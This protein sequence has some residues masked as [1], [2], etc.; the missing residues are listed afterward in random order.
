M[1]HFDTSKKPE[2]IKQNIQDIIVDTTGFYWLE[3]FQIKSN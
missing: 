3:N 1:N 2:D